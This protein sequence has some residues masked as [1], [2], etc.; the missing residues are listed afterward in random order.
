[1]GALGLFYIIYQLN[2]FLQFYLTMHPTAQAFIVISI[3]FLAYSNVKDAGLELG[4][5]RELKVKKRRAGWGKWFRC[6]TSVNIN[7]QFYLFHI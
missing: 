2:W 5:I 7:P 3:A 6:G 4:L 1:M